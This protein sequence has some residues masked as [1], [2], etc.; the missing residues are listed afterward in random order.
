[1]RWA[2]PITAWIL[3][4]IAALVV[5]F[6]PQ[7]ATTTSDAA[8][9]TLITPEAAPPTMDLSDI[10][11]VPPFDF[12]D[13]NKDPLTADMMRGKVWVGI[14]FWT[15]CNG[16][17]PAMTSRLQELQEA[18]DDKRVEMVSFSVD[19]LTDT[20]EKLKSYAE[21]RGADSARWHFATTAN[22]QAMKDF[23]R[24]ILLPY[25][26]PAEHSGR[27]FLVDKTGTIRG[28]YSH[29]SDENVKQL[30]GDIATLMAE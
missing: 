28:Y 1:M 11:D 16:I 26:V 20:P 4:A 18:V 21:A 14:L 17:C 5:S 10:A 9:F 22:P 3:A 23:A 30:R 2:L 15:E 6:L 27:I 12:I 25:D 7:R 29:D 8:T 13:A 19:P 24:T